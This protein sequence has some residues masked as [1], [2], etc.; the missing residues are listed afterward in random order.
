MLVSAVS[1]VVEGVVY[2]IVI[3]GSLDEFTLTT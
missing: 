1:L 2:V 3:N